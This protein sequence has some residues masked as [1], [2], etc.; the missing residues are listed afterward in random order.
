LSIRGYSSA[1]SQKYSTT[2]SIL[3]F[4]TATLFSDVHSKTTESTE[5]LG[6]RADSLL[7]KA[8]QL[9]SIYSYDEALQ[10]LQDALVIEQQLN[11]LDY[12]ASILHQIADILSRTSLYD[13]A[14]FYSDSALT[15]ARKTSATDIECESLIMLAAASECIS[16]YETA[17][18]YCDTAFAILAQKHDPILYV[19]ALN[20][21]SQIY[22]SMSQYDKALAYC[23]TA[24]VVARSNDDKEGEAKSLEI[25]GAV[26]DN[27]GEYHRA[28][29]NYRD[30]YSIW[31]AYGNRP[32]ESAALRSMGRSYFFLSQYDSSLHYYREALQISRQIHDANGEGQILTGIGLIF[33]QQGLNE[34]S[35]V[36]LDSALYI[37]RQLGDL[38]G[39]A[40]T[41][42]N[43]GTAYSSISKFE[44]AMANFDSSLTIMRK[45]GS[46]YIE[47]SALTSKGIIYRLLGKYEHALACFD[48]ALAI[49]DQTNDH[50]G[51]SATMNNIAIVYHT[52]RLHEK[53]LAYY[54]SSL[55]TKRALKLRQLES[56]TLHNM[57]STYRDM[58]Q[59]GRALAYFDSAL[60]IQRE[61]RDLTGEART[62]DDIGVAYFLLGQHN[63]A[64]TCLDSSLQLKKLL[65]DPWTQAI[66]LGNIGRAHHALAE[67]TSALNSFL[68]ALRTLDALQDRPHKSA[69]MEEIGRVYESTGDVDSA[70]SYYKQAIEVKEDIRSE[71]KR[72]ELR[73]PYIEAEKDIYER[74]AV[75]LIMLERYEEAFDYLERSRSEKLRKAFEMSDMVAYDPSLNRTLERI[76]LLT[77]EMEGL[78]KRFQDGDIEEALY[79]TQHNELQGRLNQ[80]M[81]DFKI[82]YPQLYSVIVPRQWVL[83]EIQGIIP[84]GTLF[85]G[86]AEVNDSYVALLFTRDMFMVQTLAEPKDSIDQRV[87]QALTALK[88]QAP[89]AEIQNQFAHLYRVLLQPSESIIVK[90]PN[91]VIIPYGILHYLPFHILRYT[92]E[93]AEH[94]YLIERKRISYLPSASFL[95][96][97]LKE[98]KNAKHELLAFGNAD[99]TLPSA[100]IEVDLIAR[101]FPRSHVCKCD[102]ARKD[103][104]IQL[105]NEYAMIHLATHGILTSDPR[106]S[107]IVL[108]PAVTGN[109]TVREIFGLSGH[110]KQTSLV[111][112]SA[113]ETAVE[114]EP[115]AAGM[116][117]VT[118]S[119]AFK[120]AGVP[121][122]I[123]SLWEIADRSTAL[124][125]EDF[126]KNLKDHKM[127]KLEALRQAQLTMLSNDQYSHPYYWAPFILIGNWQ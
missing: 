77:S 118:L 42:Y 34:L 67:Y 114:A 81:L 20:T 50:Y 9:C 79:D 111:T 56:G 37:R 33:S 22:Y 112:L 86:F 11:R 117:L 98:Q 91:I 71:L 44:H 127:D 52:L 48:S 101:L 21:I 53:A 84:R 49:A 31:K 76:N 110:F 18:A 92:D 80:I 47:G 38:R 19:R 13:S 87:I 60:I 82:H 83:K 40:T 4:L 107:Y 57:G 85:I 29:E 115:E 122:T 113:C 28:L 70:I 25:A 54:D 62:L 6:A 124:L 23:D 2:A 97:L 26:Y 106:F 27:N 45:I 100:E 43:L 90:Y 119:N 12:Q 65:K 125:M 109:L 93:Q 103:R 116:E 15:I 88:W 102:S 8:E 78:R 126:Y 74:L 39:L 32:G 24:L 58:G 46:K 75:L 64:L 108:A 105:A 95:A 69:M 59:Y 61:I 30:S 5:L 104:F 16:E 89:E 123:A 72:T 68:S 14:L 121:T 94:H 10:K 17:L 99:G 63:R 120:V 3:V 73:E 96:D 51:A 7:T 55:T 35:I 66:T 1:R 41:M 36:Y